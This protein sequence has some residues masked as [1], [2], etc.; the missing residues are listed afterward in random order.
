[1]LCDLISDNSNAANDI[2]MKMLSMTNTVDETSSD[3]ESEDLGEKYEPPN[4]TQEDYQE[5]TPKKPHEF[6]VDEKLDIK[7]QS[8]SFCEKYIKN[9]NLSISIHEI[10]NMFLQKTALEGIV[11]KHGITKVVQR[12]QTE[13]TMGR[14]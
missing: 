12:V 3:D 11:N 10:K 5:L 7:K 6:S 13:I 8:Y 9:L 1:M 2:I 4:L 14:R